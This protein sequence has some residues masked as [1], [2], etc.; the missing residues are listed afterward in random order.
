M[1]DARTLLQLSRKP[2]A[3]LALLA[4]LAGFTAPAKAAVFLRGYMSG[5]PASSMT[6]GDWDAFQA[7]AQTLL[8]QIPATPGQS[9]DWT[10]P[11]GAKGSLTI[12][13]IFLKKDMPCRKVQAHFAAKTG[14]GGHDYTLDVCR[15]DSGDWKIVS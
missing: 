1:R 5:L 4:G 14:T 9:Q 2:A 8:S 3:D 12:K 13:S 10:G 11:S 15:I 7:A 6:S